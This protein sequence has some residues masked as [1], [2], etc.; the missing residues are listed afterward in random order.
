MPTTGF[1]SATPVANANADAECPDGNDVDVGSRARRLI[2]GTSSILGRWRRHSS[3]AG[4]FVTIDVTM[5]AKI[6]R[7]AP[8]LPDRPPNAFDSA[9]IPSQSKDLLPDLV[10]GGR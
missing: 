10:S 3:F 7:R 9:A 6:P 2:C 1:S 4:M 5:I 8:R